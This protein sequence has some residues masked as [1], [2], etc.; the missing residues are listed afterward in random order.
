MAVDSLYK[1]S[2]PGMETPP[3]EVL[4]PWSSSLQTSAEALLQRR[5]MGMR[6]CPPL[7]PSAQSPGTR[8]QPLML[9]SQHTTG[10]AQKEPRGKKQGDPQITFWGEVLWGV[11]GQGSWRHGRHRCSIVSVGFT[12]TRTTKCERGFIPRWLHE[13]SG[14][15]E[16]HLLGGSGTRHALGE[17]AEKPKRKKRSKPGSLHLATLLCKQPA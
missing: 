12:R 17:G 9:G 3:E 14:G 16:G 4:L 13:I 11:E 7:S 8:T 5:G 1:S 10:P 6:L 2:C 15:A